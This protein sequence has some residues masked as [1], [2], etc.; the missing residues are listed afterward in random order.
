MLISVPVFNETTYMDDNDSYDTG[1]KIMSAFEPG[2][3]AFNYM[4]KSFVE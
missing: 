3:D 2:S 4:F 1:L